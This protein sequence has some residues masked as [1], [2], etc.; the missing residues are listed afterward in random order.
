M[1]SSYGG[2]LG[3]SQ[4]SGGTQNTG[5]LPLT[6]KQISEAAQNSSDDTFYI[7]GID[8]NNVTILGMVHNKEE[9]STDVSFL[10]DDG[11]GRVE[12]KRWID[13]QDT[14]E[15]EQIAALQ[16]GVYV[17]VHGHLRSFQGKRNIVAFSVRP[18]TDFNEVT[19]H[20]LECIFVHLHNSKANGMA[21]K[22]PSISSPNYGNPVGGGAPSQYV[23]PNMTGVGGSMDECQ[24]RVHSVFEEPSSLSS[25]VG[26]HIDDVARRI[27]GF[28]KKQVKDAIEFLVNEGLIYSTIDDD[29]YKS[30][31]G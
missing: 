31:N 29:H 12:V 3:L 8:V 17:R 4:K 13:G 15:N 1:Q 5:L 7:D 19:Y 18:V 20:F 11:T 25:E 30:T 10:L 21:V 27:P 28:T 24:K 26:L 14:F 22:G 6:V 16:D 9:R 2:V 23:T